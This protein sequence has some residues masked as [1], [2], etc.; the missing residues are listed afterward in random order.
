[1]GKTD[2]AYEY[3]ATEQAFVITEQLP[4]RYGMN[5]EFEYRHN[6][7]LSAF[8][9]IDNLLF[10]RYYYWQN[11]PSQRALFTLGITYTIPT[12]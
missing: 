10:Q 4:L 2:A 1:M 5:F 11:Y 9:K 6:K 12:K 3:D 7:A 8:L